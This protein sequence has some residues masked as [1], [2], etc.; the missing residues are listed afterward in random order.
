V[1]ELDCTLPDQSRGFWLKV[2]SLITIETAA[3][4]SRVAE[5]QARI[6]PTQYPSTAIQA[7]FVA[8]RLPSTTSAAP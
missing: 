8:T 4:F 6:P 3:G 7:V 2:G 5:S 1:Q